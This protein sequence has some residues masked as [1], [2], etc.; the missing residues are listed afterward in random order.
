MKKCQSELTKNCRN[1]WCLS[2]KKLCVIIIGKGAERLSKKHKKKLIAILVVLILAAVNWVLDIWQPSPGAEVPEGS[3]L[4]VDFVDVGQADFIVIECD[5]VYMTIDGGNV[6]DS[7]KVYSYLQERGIKE[8]QTVV[9]T[10]AHEDHCGGVSALLNCVEAQ[11]VYCP[12]TEYDTKAFRNVVSAVH[13]QGL[14]LTVPVVGEVFSLGS[15]QVQV[16]GP[17]KEYEDPNDTSIVLRI[18]YGE[19]AFVFTGDAESTSEHDILDAGFDVSADVLKVGHHGSSTSSSYVWLKAVAPTYAVISSNRTEE[20]DYN[21]PHEEV[22]SRLRDEEATVYRTD[23]QGTITCIS[24][25]KS[26]AFTV[27]RNPDAD[28]L[29][30]AGDGGNHK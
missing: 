16:I 17:V 28:T 4:R 7:Q 14:E 12:V 30:D 24:D 13:S 1:F 25:G 20:P 22:V 29:F 2:R 3:Y 19:H 18:T 8:V 27:T 5:G 11:T 9:V 26:I 21:H 15:A 10:H 23:L 6:A